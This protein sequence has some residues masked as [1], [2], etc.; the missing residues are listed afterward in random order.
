MEEH[1]GTTEKLK[2]RKVAGIDEITSKR[3]NY[4]LETG[5]EL[6]RSYSMLK[7]RTRLPIIGVLT[8]IPVKV[9]DTIIEGNFF[10]KGKNSQDPIIIL[11][12]TTEKE[13]G[14]I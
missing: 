2:I 11:K 8:S 12:Q 13:S 6:F 10:R 14:K 3:I 9:L 5:I 7:W 1:N 4:L